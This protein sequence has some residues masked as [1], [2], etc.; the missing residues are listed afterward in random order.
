MALSGLRNRPAFTIR[1]LPL[2]SSSLRAKIKA[3][4]Y[5]RDWAQRI[6][7][8]PLVPKL[9]IRT[10]LFQFP[11]FIKE[12]TGQLWLLRILI[13]SIVCVGLFIKCWTILLSICSLSRRILRGTKI[14]GGRIRRAASMSSLKFQKLVITGYST[15]SWESKKTHAGQLN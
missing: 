5:S 11:F 4:Y 14:S 13:I 9:L 10:H 2:T 8:W 3:L 6:L 1:V 12:S 7:L 15:A